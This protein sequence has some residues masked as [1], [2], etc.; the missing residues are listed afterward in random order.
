MAPDF[1]KP[2][3]LMVDAS[4]IGAGAVLMQR[5][6]KDIEHP[7]CY[8]S[9]KLTHTRRTILLLKKRPW[10]YSLLFNILMYI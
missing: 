4:D 10:L 8:F 7:I 2:F 5:D 1:H 3:L 6:E 9:R